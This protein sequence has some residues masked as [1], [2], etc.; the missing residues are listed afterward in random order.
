MKIIEG[1]EEVKASGEFDTMPA[2]GYVMT[3]IN[4]EDV[5]AKEYLKLE[6]E[7]GEGEWTGHAKATYERASFWP[8]VCYRS[9]KESAQGMFKAFTNAVE[10]SNDGYTWNW[11]ERSLEGLDVGVV[12][13]NEHYVKNNGNLGTRLVVQNIKS[14]Q[15]IRDGKFKVPEDKWTDEAK[16]LKEQDNADSYEKAMADNPFA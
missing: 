10:A 14:A 12:F 7:V 8:L 13:A 2:G 16:A 5:E 9:Y 11:N 4:A 6:L 3:I 15:D 1:W